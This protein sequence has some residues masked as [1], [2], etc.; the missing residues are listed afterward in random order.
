MRKTL[1]QLLDDLGELQVSMSYAQSMIFV[2]QAI[3]RVRLMN[4][5]DDR[6]VTAGEIA[7]RSGLHAPSVERVLAF[8]ASEGVVECHPGHRYAHTRRSR[9]FQRQA[10]GFQ[11]L[12][13]SMRGG[14]GLPR[15][16]ETGRPGFEC[17]TGQPIF[18]YLA[19]NPD[20][21][22]YF[23]IRMSFMT[24]II[25]AW[26]FSQH[27]FEPF[28]LA[29]D[30][31]GSHGHMMKRLLEVHSSARGIVF[32]LPGTAER[33]R[34]FLADNGLGDRADA[35][36]GDFFEAVPA[37]GDLY[38]L[39]QILH[40][41][42]DEESVT[43]LANIRRAIARNGRLA[44]IDFLLPDGNEPHPGFAL[45]ILMLISTTGRERR[46]AEFES[47]F[48]AAGFRIDRLTENPRGQSVIE[49]VPA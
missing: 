43:I 9:A 10:E 19:E 16:L 17:E 49:A 36:G 20:T 1:G 45:D 5:L 42:D 4:Y 39:K 29:V 27:R 41:W 13:E 25:E 37:G 6:P 23:G 8:L 46:L 30:V 44:V 24:E 35:V 33:A 47:I 26:V 31:G 11:Y 38:L 3:A 2:L 34:R 22:E 15:T 32:D 14:L 21:V 18:D 48:D 12:Q 40:D 7:E 28:E